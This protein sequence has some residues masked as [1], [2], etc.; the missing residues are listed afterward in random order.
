MKL[1]LSN[2]IWLVTV[3]LDKLCDNISSVKLSSCLEI[4]KGGAI[5][6]LTVSNQIVE[7]ISLGYKK[8]F[9]FNVVQPIN[10]V[11]CNMIEFMEQ[12]VFNSADFLFRS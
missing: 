1:R 12:N 7:S 3:K 6:W 9:F 2:G 11:F 10:L 5:S 8:S 4:S